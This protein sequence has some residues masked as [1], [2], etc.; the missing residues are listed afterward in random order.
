V[1]CLP[2]LEG[3]NAVNPRRKFNN[4]ITGSELHSFSLREALAAAKREGI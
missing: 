3:M 1:K 2:M 4:L